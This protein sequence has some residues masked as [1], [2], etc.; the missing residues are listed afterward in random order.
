MKLKD[1]LEDLLDLMGKSHAR[2][3][4]KGAETMK[5]EI[6]QWLELH[7]MTMRQADHLVSRLSSPTHKQGC[8]LP[9]NL[10]AGIKSFRDSGGLSYYITHAFN[11]AVAAKRASSIALMMDYVSPNEQKESIQ[12]LHTLLVALS[13]NIDIFFGTDIESDLP[14]L[15]RIKQGIDNSILPAL[16]QD[17]RE[18]NIDIIEKYPDSGCEFFYRADRSEWLNL[19]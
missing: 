6:R 13:D 8:S 12:E 1:T 7:P 17:M 3:N 15:Y 10:N 5:A 14:H 16:E 9:I 11:D 18:L 4:T 2:K 19:G